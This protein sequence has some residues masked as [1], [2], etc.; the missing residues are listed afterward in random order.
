MKNASDALGMPPA[1][2]QAKVPPVLLL[3]LPRGRAGTKGIETKA[4]Y[5][6]SSAPRCQTQLFLKL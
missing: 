6:V 2:S 3:R 5:P 1:I 4:S